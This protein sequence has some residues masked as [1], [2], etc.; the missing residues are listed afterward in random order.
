M[1]IE[2]CLITGIAFGL[3]YQELEKGYVVIDLGIIRILISKA[4][5]E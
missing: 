4:D 3:E 5:E 1:E 2:F